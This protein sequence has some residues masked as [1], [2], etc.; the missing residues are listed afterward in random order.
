MEEIDYCPFC[1]EKGQL[2]TKNSEYIV[3]CVNEN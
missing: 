3:T 1:G 2:V